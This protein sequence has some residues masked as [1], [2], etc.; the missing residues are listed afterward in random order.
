MRILVVEDD[1]LARGA[2]RRI[3]TADGHTLRAVADGHRAVAALKRF[4][5][6][7]IVMDWQVPGLAGELLYLEVRRLK[8]G[9]PIVIVSSAEEA[10]E[11]DVDV[12]ARLRKPLDV[13]QL[14]DAVAFVGK[15]QRI[16]PPTRAFVRRRRLEE[17]I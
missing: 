10:F 8:P 11:S 3:L 14:R 13:R 15:H 12:N 1:A 6:H 4:D 7:L 5:P 17:K 2:L 16:G 9:I